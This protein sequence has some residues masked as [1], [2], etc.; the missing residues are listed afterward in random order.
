[1][2]SDELRAVHG[3]QPAGRDGDQWCSKCL[4]SPL[5]RIHDVEAGRVTD[6]APPNGLADDLAAA[7]HSGHRPG[8]GPPD[9]CAHCRR[10]VPLLLP[11]VRAYAAAKL[12]AVA[13]YAVIAA[14]AITSLVTHLLN[15]ENR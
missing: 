4:R 15:G 1:M 10:E 5:D 3:Y 2:D 8:D 7:L 6:P 14:G 11:V 12:D 13:A 9:E